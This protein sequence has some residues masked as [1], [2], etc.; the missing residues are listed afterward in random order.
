MMEDW[1]IGMMEDWSDGVMEDWNDG[2][3]E[4]WRIGV[5]MFFK[6]HNYL[7][8]RVIFISR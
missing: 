6:T 1:K 8:E 3:L 4:D 5:I 2:R 7:F